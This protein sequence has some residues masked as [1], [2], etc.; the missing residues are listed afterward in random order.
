MEVHDLET[1]STEDSDSGLQENDIK[2]VR[3]QE[4]VAV[5]PEP[6]RLGGSE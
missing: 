6:F 4:E 1:F 3:R 5:D 2:R